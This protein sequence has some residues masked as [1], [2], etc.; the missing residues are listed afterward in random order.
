MKNTT[1][2]TTLLPGVWL[3]WTTT[4]GNFF[5]DCATGEKIEKL[6]FKIM[7]S[8]RTKRVVNSNS[9]PRFAYA[10]YHEDIEALEVAEVTLNTTRTAEPKAW[11]YAGEKYFIKKD[12]TV[13][14]ENGNEKTHSF[15]LSPQH[16][17]YDFKG[18]LGMFYRIETPFVVSEFKK[19]L[20]SETYNVGSGRVV[21]VAHA[22]HIQEWYKTKQKVRGI[23]KQQKLTNKL[24]AM[25]V[26]DNEE[27]L[28]KYPVEVPTDKY[29]RWHR[30]GIICFERLT[31]GWSVLRVFDR[32]GDG[33]ITEKERMY[34]HDDGASRIVTPTKDGWV[35]SRQN[36]WYASYKFENQ[37]EAMEKCNRLKYILPLVRDESE[38]N[39][40][41][42]LMTILRFPEIEQ[43]MS[44]GYT[45][46]AYAI[47]H[48]NTPKADLK[49]MFGDYY[50]NKE[51]AI[52]RKAGL[53]KHQ[54][55][56]Y[57]RSYASERYYVNKCAGALREMRKMFGDTLTHL[58]NSSFDEYYD[59]FVAMWRGY[60]KQVF[61]RLEGMNIDRTRFIKNAF[62]LGK[63][64]N[65]IYTL[66]DDTLN[67]YAALNMGTHPE[68]NWYFDSY[69]DA[70][71]AHDAIDEL[72][73][74]QDAE[75]RAI[76][77]KAEAERLKKE[78][79]KR[80]EIDKKR[81]EYEY[82]DDTYVIRLP[83]GYNEIVREGSM[84]R[85]CIGGYTSRH[86]LGQTN[87]FFLRRK[88]E[89]TVPFYAI[90]MDN[91]K[92]IVQIHGYCNS[93]LGN[94]P[95]A[96]PTVVR[97]LRKNGIKCDEKIL[98]CKAKGYGMVND[99]V[100]MPVVD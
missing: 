33:K 47:A 68:I 46:A 14:D 37:R 21:P 41:R 61:S 78:D 97:W 59:G 85:I 100:K 26:M 66:L 20:G 56:H 64:N 89:P 27:V 75:R 79:Q 65:N 83:E 10:K 90:E 44:L 6:P 16:R 49:H 94:N 12:K 93:W 32:Y 57:M 29:Y 7:Y 67:Q 39:L 22:W 30:K 8:D 31:D 13:F 40:K 43:M 98:T 88:S 72:K 86:A 17:S 74:M 45:R 36:N 9:R 82:E 52:L 50:N 15:V 96:I 91:T 77:N 80:I 92:K 73:R 3:M 48:S 34:L 25:T 81:K 58:D 2:D 51:K 70:V 55:E 38:T 24:T 71:R 63:K 99:Y 69:S 62:R 54:M 84:Q 23:G 1:I 18:L 60:G 53:N 42:T 4:K 28:A 5:L 11:R 19:F 87:L 76:W 95:E 35:P